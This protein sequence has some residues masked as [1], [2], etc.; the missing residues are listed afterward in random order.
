[1]TTVTTLVIG[2]TASAREAAIQPLLADASTAVILEGLPDGQALLNSDLSRHLEIT[3]IAP[4]CLCCTGNLVMR[5]TLNRLLRNQPSRLFIGV[6]STE[7]LTAL[8]TFLKEAPYD[9]ILHLTN[10][11]T[12]T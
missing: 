11:V 2:G 5:V 8:R 7:H 6:A 10:D 3:R 12:L 1:M 9:H 4:S